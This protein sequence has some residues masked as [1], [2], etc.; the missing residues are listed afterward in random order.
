M[1]SAQ[2]CIG[3][4]DQH[5]ISSLREAASSATA[6][7]SRAARLMYDAANGQVTVT[8]Q[9]SALPLDQGTSVSPSGL[10][11]LLLLLLFRSKISVFHLLRD[12]NTF[13][14]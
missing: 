2:R 1:A 4:Q 8:S 11:L 14:V 7:D 9:H 12:T 13:T 6:P 10:L 5:N 3:H